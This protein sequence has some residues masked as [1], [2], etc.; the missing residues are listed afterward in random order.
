MAFF[1]R[2]P[3]GSGKGPTKQGLTVLLSGHFLGIA[4]SVFSK[5]S[6][7]A[8]NPYEVLRDGAGFSGKIFFAPKVGKMDQNRPKTGFFQFIG[9]F[10]N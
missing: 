7:G 4:S 10:G 9:K 5:F 2:P 6:Q 1:I 8:R 3:S